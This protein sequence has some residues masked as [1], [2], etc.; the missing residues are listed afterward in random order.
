MIKKKFDADF[1]GGGAFHTVIHFGSGVIANQNNCQLGGSALF[2]EA[3]HATRGLNVDFFGDCFA[4][5]DS[6]HN[7]AILAQICL[8][9]KSVLAGFVSKLFQSKV[10][11]KTG[12]GEDIDARSD[13]F[14]HENAEDK[15]FVVYFENTA[16]ITDDVG[17]NEWKKAPTDYDGEFIPFEKTGIFF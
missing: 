14:V 10:V 7:A 17:R 15:F 3:S 8:N 12:T 13:A 5:D 11:E 16:N 2:F 9:V 6:G 4:V 1:F